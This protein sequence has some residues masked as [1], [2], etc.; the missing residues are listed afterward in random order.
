M[1][2]SVMLGNVDDKPSKVDIE[3]HDISKSILHQN[4]LK[5][6]QDTTAGWTPV[7]A[8]T[9]VT[10]SHYLIPWAVPELHAFFTF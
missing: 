8:A 2:S 4:K 5:K 10:D 3:K 6:K 7:A 9:M 1:K